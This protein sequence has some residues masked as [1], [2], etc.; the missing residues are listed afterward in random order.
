[1]SSV[2]APHDRANEENAHPHLTRKHTLLPRTR[3]ELHQAF[4]RWI[5]T[6]SER[7]RSVRHEID[8]ENLRRQEREHYSVSLDVQSNYFCE[9]DAEEHRHH[10]ANVR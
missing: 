6:Q 10:F 7:G 8:P 9:H 3:R 1:M 2:P 4:V 5:N